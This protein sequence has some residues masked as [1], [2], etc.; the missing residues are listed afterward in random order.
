MKNLFFIILFSLCLFSV[1]GEEEATLN[2]SQANFAETIANNNYVL[3][4]FYAPWCGH[5]KTLKPE[6]E[7]AAQKTKGKYVLA[8]V[9]CTV[10]KDLCGQYS[11]RGYPTVKFFKNGNQLEYDGARNADGIIS[12]LDRKSGPPA[13]DLADAQA[14]NDFTQNRPVVVGYFSNKDT[15]AYKNF[16]KAAE[17]PSSADF[18]FGVVSDS[19]LFNGNNDGAIVLLAK[20]K[21]VTVPS[22]H[23][24]NAE[25]IAKYLFD[26]S[27]PLIQEVDASNFKHY[28]TRA[29][30][31]M[32]AWLKTKD[33]TA[34]EQIETFKKIAADYPQYSFGYI[35]HENFGANMERM[36]G[37]GK[38]VPAITCLSFTDNKPIVFERENEFNDASIREWIDG[39]ISGKYK[40]QSKSEPVPADN[41]GPV[42][43]IVGTTFDQIV[44]DSNKDV[45]VEFYAPWCGHC[46]NLIPEY[47]KLGKAF[48]GVKDVV[49]GKI[50]LTANDVD[51]SHHDVKGFPTI[52]LYPRDKK[53]T[54]VE[55][56]GTRDAKSLASWI[57]DN[58]GSSEAKTVNHDEL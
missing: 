37:S 53:T 14:I 55:Y 25:N 36:G 42:V 33:S 19:S 49:I 26:S 30:R 16:L 31:L 57:K 35:S 17:N 50:D 10:E 47:E 41:N 54:P 2:L 38:V 40:Y 28:V 29:K 18:K 7:I 4:M 32:L 44:H 43:T 51:S 20:D 13:V 24:D 52:L 9:D 15:E 46:K 3:A 34:A 27:F 56:K 8:K 11:I 45:V 48:A 22:E 6:Y 23:S 58:T 12:W 39:V 21:D 5:C 1:F